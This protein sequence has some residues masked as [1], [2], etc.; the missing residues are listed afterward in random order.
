MEHTLSLKDYAAY[1]TELE[2]KRRTS[3]D[4][5]NVTIEGESNF[6]FDRLLAESSFEGLPLDFIASSLRLEEVMSKIWHTHT[7]HGEKKLKLAIGYIPP[8][9]NYEYIIIDNVPCYALNY[10]LMA[11]FASDVCI[12]PL[13]LTR[14]DLGRTISMMLK[15]QEYANIYEM[16][17][18]T[19]FNKLIF[20]FNDVAHY[21]NEERIKNYKKELL[22]CIPKAKIFDEIIARQIGFTRINTK[23][24]TAKDVSNVK[25]KFGPFFKDFIKKMKIHL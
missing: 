2:D 15:L 19:F 5:L 20:I 6:D 4:L 14:N 11:V 22:K 7:G 21:I 8:R 9:L 10:A 3:A 18:D 17:K 16:S 24:S 1:K 13:R 25:E 12:I 23:E